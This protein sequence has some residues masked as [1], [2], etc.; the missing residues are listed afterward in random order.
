MRLGKDKSFLTELLWWWPE[1]LL[2]WCSEHEAY[3]CM[4]FHKLRWPKERLHHS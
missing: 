2:W 1:P 3:H 4:P